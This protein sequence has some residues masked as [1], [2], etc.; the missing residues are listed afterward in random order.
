MNRISHTLMFFAL[1]YSISWTLWIVLFARHLSHL[2]GAGLLLYL[3]AVFAPHA[4]AAINTAVEG[5][6]GGLS[7]FYK[8][9]FRPLPIRWVIVATAVPPLV[10]LLRDG[11][12]VA[13]G[14]NHGA[15]F[16]RP[17]RTL[18]VLLLGQLAVVFGEEPGWRGFALPRLIKR[19][20]PLVGTLLLGI[21]WTV[22]HLP[23][24]LIRG[25]AQYG[26]GFMPFLVLLTA[27]S[28]VITLVVMRGRG[29]IIGAMLFHA[30]ANVCAFSM[31]E[32]K[33]VGLALAPWAVVAVIAAWK[34]REWHWAENNWR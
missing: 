13:F 26:S 8:M 17:P 22:W 27:W 23:L 28:M 4:S 20:G 32:P 29:S 30:S 9:I 7:A 11:L 25:T 31:W 2:A 24:F 6:W 18:A 16:Q 12:V 1:A 3:F 34:M 14:F 15:F 33:P 21:G 10:Y 5:G 19:T